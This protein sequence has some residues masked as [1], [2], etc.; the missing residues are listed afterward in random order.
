MTDEDVEQMLSHARDAI[1]RRMNADHC[2]RCKK[3]MPVEVTGVYFG[4]QLPSTG[5]EPNEAWQ[6]TWKPAEQGWA[7]VEIGTTRYS[8]CPTCAVELLPFKSEKRKL[9]PGVDYPPG[10]PPPIPDLEV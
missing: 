6:V 1:K 7:F 2:K 5:V 9:I 10:C 3:A 4:R 8:L